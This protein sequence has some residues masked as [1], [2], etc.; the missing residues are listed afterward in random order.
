[1]SFAV[2]D[3]IFAI[4]VVITLIGGFARGFVENVLNKLGWIFAVILSAMF[5]EQMAFKLKAYIS[6]DFL[7]KLAGFFII[8][9]IV[10]LVIMILK[11]ILSKLFSGTILG[12]LDKA[13]GGLFG[14]VEGIAISFIII[15]LLELQPIFDVSPLLR[16]S[17]FASLM[18]SV[19]S[20]F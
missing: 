6:N 13:L 19:T 12:G 15:F 4:I 3:F 2:I 5:Y 8:F 20:Q 1:M 17:F 18:N 7:S 14:V 10:F 16:G 11:V 9:A